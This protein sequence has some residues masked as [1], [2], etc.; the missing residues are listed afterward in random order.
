[1][2]LGRSFFSLYFL[3]ISVFIIFSWLLDEVWSSYLEQDIESYTGYKT[4]LNAVGDYLH[5]HPED[6]WPKLVS[7]F[8]TK[9]NITLGLDNIVKIDK[10]NLENKEQLIGGDTY[11][12]Y[13]SDEVILHHTL[14]DKG[15]LLTLGPAKMPTRPRVEALMRVFILATFAII[16]FA[17]LWPISKDLDRL[18]K[19]TKL[20]GQGDF[21]VRA[22]EAKSTM[23]KSMVSAFNMMAGRIKKLIEAH[24]ELTNAVSHELRTPLARTKFALQM[25][26]SVED[27]VKREKYL[28]QITDD[29]EELESLVNEMLVYAAFES[30]RPILKVEPC[31]IGKLVDEQ[32]LSLHQNEHNI[33]IINRLDDLLVDC[34]KHFIG[35]A[36]NSYITNAIKYGNGEIKICIYQENE[37]CVISVEDNGEGVTP[38]FKPVIFNAF[39]R[40]DQSRNRETGGFGL[41]LAIVAKIM[42]WHQGKSE[43]LDSDLGGASF[44][45]KWPISH[46][47]DV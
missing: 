5:K 1:M 27:D 34:D 4:M 13:D 43:V 16:I 18:R 14:N 6:E 30:D 41:G 24:T 32:I 40:D 9:Y 46:K 20:L 26:S 36:L 37:N 44:L 17:W 15:T 38:E 12:Y 25:L 11:I 42:D 35:R 21:R 10:K 8:G 3:I 39:S 22:P 7:N 29:V 19:T 31:N 45:L 23:M 33:E 47:T 28:Q 2:K